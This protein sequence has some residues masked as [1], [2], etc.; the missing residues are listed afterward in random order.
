MVELEKGETPPKV[1]AKKKMRGDSNFDEDLERRPQV[2]K[3]NTDQTFGPNPI[4]K[5]SE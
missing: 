2:G 4:E 5:L 1:E 3:E